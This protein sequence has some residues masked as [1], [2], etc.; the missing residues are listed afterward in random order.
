MGV[1]FSALRR[2]LGFCAVLIFFS[3]ASRQSRADEDQAFDLRSIDGRL[4]LVPRVLT[5]EQSEQNCWHSGQDGVDFEDAS[6]SGYFNGRIFVRSHR[7]V[8][9][10][11][12]WRQNFHDWQV[13]DVAISQA[14]QQVTAQY[15]VPHAGGYAGCHVPLHGTGP[16]A[17]ADS[18]S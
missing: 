6:P 14:S 5:G 15:T 9:E 18:T 16:H 2:G 8:I 13:I 17:D 12:G 3:I 1:S 4:V 11:G 10:V 7:D